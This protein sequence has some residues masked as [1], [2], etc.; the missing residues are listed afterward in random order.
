[1]SKN[2]TVGFG[3]SLLIFAAA[4]KLFKK[5]NKKPEPTLVDRLKEPFS[6]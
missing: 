5:L 4:A 3:T 1:M 2:K 6:K